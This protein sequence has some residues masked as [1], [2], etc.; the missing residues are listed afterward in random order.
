MKQTIC[1]LTST[2]AALALFLSACGGET[3]PTPDAAAISTAA[4]Q[5]VE[6]RF[7]LQAVLQAT[8][9]PL[10]PT[11]TPGPAAT[12]TLGYPPTLT[13]E[14]GLPTPTSNGK[15]CYVMTFVSDITIPDGMIIAPGAAFTK[16]WRVRNDGNCV[17]DKNYSLELDKGDAM[18]TATKIPL[19]KVVNPGD[20]IDLSIDMTA[21]TKDGIYSG[22]WHIATPYG[23]YIGIAGYNQSL[24]VKIQVTNKADRYFGAVSVVYD[25]NRKPP[26][27]CG[28]DGAVYNFSATIT[29]NG[30]GEIEYQWDRVPWDGDPLQG[31]TLKFTEAGSKTVYFTWS[32]HNGQIQNI[33]RWVAIEILGPNPRTFDRVKFYHTCQP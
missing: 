20:S 2:L 18:S 4:A 25:Y 19:T 10:P 11:E 32:L 16:T 15:A 14:P 30:P 13:T 8:E 23:G 33:D 1:I 28:S 6:A 21:P 24:F 12:P 9:T 3:Q 7:T 17:W 5:T 26:K 27:G 22:Y 29:V 31:G